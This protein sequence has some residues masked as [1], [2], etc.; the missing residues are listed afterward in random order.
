MSIFFI[1]FLSFSIV[2]AFLFIF[3]KIIYFNQTKIIITCQDKCYLGFLI[4]DK[5]DYLNIL[6]DRKTLFIK[7]EDINYIEI[8]DEKEIDENSK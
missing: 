7:K 6:S 3:S 8:F 1:I 4:Q 2:F 5:D